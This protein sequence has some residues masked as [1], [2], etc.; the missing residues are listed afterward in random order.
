MI[1]ILLLIL[2][3]VKMTNS[4]LTDFFQN[5]YTGIFE[6]ADQDFVI[7]LS[8]FKMAEP[9]WLLKFRRKLRFDFKLYTEF[10]GVADE[11]FL[12]KLSKFKM[13]DTI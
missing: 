10:F 9:I 1:K 6:D 11:D 4:K 3:K 13:A 8:K 7:G 12:I 5:S 2:P